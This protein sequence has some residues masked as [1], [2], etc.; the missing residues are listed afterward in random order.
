MDSESSSSHLQSSRRLLFPFSSVSLRE[1]EKKCFSLTRK[2]KF[3]AI[4]AAT[5]HAHS[6]FDA[7]KLFLFGLNDRLADSNSASE[8]PFSDFGAKRDFNYR[9]FSFSFR[10]RRPEKLQLGLK[11]ALANHPRT[12]NWQK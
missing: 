4:D 2:S 1:R 7:F 9:S 3:E 12:S 8:M 10:R 11:N 6:F 5:K